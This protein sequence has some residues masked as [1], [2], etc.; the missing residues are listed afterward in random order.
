MALATA[1]EEHGPAF[2]GGQLGAGRAT[3]VFL[4]YEFVL[5]TVCTVVNAGMQG[6]NP[7]DP[8]QA[9]ELAQTITAPAAILG[10]AVGGVA[11]LLMSR[12]LLREHLR[13]TSPTGGAWVP[14]PLRGILY[15]LAVGVL[16]GLCGCM[17][18]LLFGPGW[19]HGMGPLAKLAATPGLSRALWIVMAV[20][21]APPIEE[22]L[23]RGIIYGGYRRPFGPGWAAVLATSLFV[24]GHVTEVVHFSPFIVSITGLAI[25]ALWMR[26]RFASIGPAIAVHF[27]YNA[28]IVFTIV[29]FAR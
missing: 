23:F 13:D 27:G 22:L 25:A 9:A 2:G 1:S 21:L 26:L 24:I 17:V 29:C 16:T 19:R 10:M 14:G 7:A 12:L 8:E 28:V 15:G 11:M 6:K 4:A 3:V 18:A 20:V 5:G